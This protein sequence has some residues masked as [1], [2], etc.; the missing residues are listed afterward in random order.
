[1]SINC[2]TISATVALK[3]RHGSLPTNKGYMAEIDKPK[4][5]P[6]SEVLKSLVLYRGAWAF[7][8]VG[9]LYLFPAHMS[10]AEAEEAIKEA[11]EIN[12][13]GAN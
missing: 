5:K 12:E 2:G 11:Y 10:K 1:M 9:G 13:T 7:E 8:G 6:L 3:L 4:Y